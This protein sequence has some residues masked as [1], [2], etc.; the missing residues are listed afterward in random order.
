MINKTLFL[1]DIKELLQNY[2]SGLLPLSKLV[3]KLEE[4]AYAY[5][6]ADSLWIQ[7]FINYWF[8]LEE[9]NALLLDDQ[10]NNLSAE[11]ELLINNCIKNI[12]VLVDNELNKI[13]PCG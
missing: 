6:Q 1:L 12:T 2:L 4:L 9:V 10:R 5:S 13:L 7:S 11:E 3:P 8:P